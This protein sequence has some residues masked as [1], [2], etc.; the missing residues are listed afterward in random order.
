M[1]ILR[2]KRAITEIFFFQIEPFAEV[3][4]SIEAYVSAYL[5]RGGAYGDGTLVRVGLPVTLSYQAARSPGKKWCVN[6]SA[7]LTALELSAGI[8]YQWWDWWGWD[9]GTRHILYE[10]GRWSAINRNWKVIERCS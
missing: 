5:I 7:R 4:A 2:R 8:F 1:G 3:T 6:L 9:W 10:F